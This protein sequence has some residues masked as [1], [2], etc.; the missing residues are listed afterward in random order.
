VYARGERVFRRPLPKLTEL[1]HDEYPHQ[2][3]SG[4]FCTPDQ[5]KTVLSSYLELLVPVYVLF[6][7]LVVFRPQLWQCGYHHNPVL[8]QE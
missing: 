5:N 3:L 1:T 8:N 7:V 2:A 6:C 4:A